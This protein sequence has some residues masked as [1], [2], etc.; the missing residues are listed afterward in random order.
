MVSDS[1]TTFKNNPYGQKSLHLADQG[2]SHLAKPVLPYFSK[3]YSLVAPYI[4]KADSLGAQGLSRVDRTF[5]IVMEDTET[6]KKKIV[7]YVTLP[8]QVANDGKQYVLDK[9]RD[10]YK[11]SG[12]EGLFAF[13]KAIV[14]TGMLVT[15][16]SLAW[17]SS[18][19]GAKKDEAKESATNAVNHNGR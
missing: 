14:T 11:N 1:I 7:G 18:F 9:Y 16:D 13:G 10:E 6:L 2:Y 3:P 15:S 17:V 19:L 12:G 5:P 8:I 4:E